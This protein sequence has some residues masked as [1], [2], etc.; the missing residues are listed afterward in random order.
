MCAYLQVPLRPPE[1]EIV[2]HSAAGRRRVSLPQLA[3]LIHDRIETA[4]AFDG[5]PIG[6]SDCLA[7]GAG[8]SLG[9]AH[10]SGYPGLEHPVGA[11]Q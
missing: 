5:V 11:V 9:L 1:A 6:I 7:K 10:V 4:M 2:D 3:D 8:F